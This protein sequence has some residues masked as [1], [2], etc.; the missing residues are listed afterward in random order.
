LE[1]LSQIFGEASWK[2]SPM[3][4]LGKYSTR[5]ERSSQL[6]EDPAGILD[7]RD[8]WGAV[9]GYWAEPLIKYFIRAEGRVM[10]SLSISA[11]SNKLHPGHKLL[12]RYKC[13]TK[14]HISNN[15]KCR[16]C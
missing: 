5:C 11:G 14:V 3:K 1:H 12:L 7:R 16:I 4:L 2:I 9:R 15:T 10:N 6:M 13:Y 8:I